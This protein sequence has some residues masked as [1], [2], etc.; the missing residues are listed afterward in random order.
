LNA[1][2]AGPPK[3]TR[4]RLAELEAMEG[5]GPVAAAAPAAASAAP[6]NNSSN[7][8]DEALKA[9]DIARNIDFL[10]VLAGDKTKLAAD[11]TKPTEGYI[12]F[13]G[14]GAKVGG[15]SAVADD[16]PAQTN[17]TGEKRKVVLNGA[18]QIAKGTSDLESER[19][20]RAAAVAA[21]FSK[22]ADSAPASDII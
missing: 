14:Q 18:V 15:D 8:S 12:P 20:K 16:I 3:S 19:A 1:K 10:R 9:R 17:T 21:R 7:L 4:Q 13:G 6:V 22:P 5:G 2:P 11:P